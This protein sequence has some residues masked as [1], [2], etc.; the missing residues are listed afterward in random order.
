[1]PLA[2]IGSHLAN[3]AAS[4]MA[5]LALAS[6]RR[7]KLRSELEQRLARSPEKQEAFRSLIEAGA[8]SYA[9][10]REGRAHWQL[11]ACGRMR[12]ALLRVGLVWFARDASNPLRTCF[13]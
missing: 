5:L 8:V 4:P 11:I 9:P 3:D 1:M 10:I 6:E 12:L 7:E 2:I 13:F